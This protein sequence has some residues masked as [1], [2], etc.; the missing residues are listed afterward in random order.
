MPIAEVLRRLRAAGLDSLPGGGAEIFARARAQEDLRRQVHAATSGWRSTAPP[1]SMGLR[2]NCTMLYGPIETVEERVDHMLR[3]RA[4]QDETGGFQTLHPAGLPPRQQRADEAAR[5]RPASRTCAPTRSR[6]CMLDNIPHIKAYWI[7]LGV[8]TAQTALWFGADDLDGTVQEEKHL[9]HGRRRDAAGDDARPRSSASSATRAARRSSATRCT[10][11]SPRARR[12]CRTSRSG[13][14]CAA[15]WRSCRERGEAR[16][17]PR[18]SF[19]NARPITYG[20][21]HGAGATIASSCR[22]SCRR[23][24]RELLR[25]RRGRPG[26]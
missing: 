14:T 13:A 15:A 26:A 17:S 25:A 4:L 9:S 16:S 2:S 20:L 1:T 12:W 5:R 24:A 11:S 23:A 6:A 22:S 19:L 7:M 21:E 3:L 10:T 18:V 8:K